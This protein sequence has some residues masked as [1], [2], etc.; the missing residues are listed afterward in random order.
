[1]NQR[2]LSF[3]VLIADLIWSLLAMSAAILLRYGTTGGSV[4]M[5]ATLSLVP[6]LSAT[7][8]IWGIL[9]L[10]VPLHGF[11]GGWRLSAVTSQLVLF[12]TC[13]LLVLLSGGYLSRSYVSRLV[14][15]QFGFLL[16]AGFILVRFV[17]YVLLRARSQNGLARRAVIV[18]RG[19][20][21]M[22]LAHKIE[23]HPE[24]LCRVIGF[25]AP[26]E[27]SLEGD[28]LPF[29]PQPST[30]TG[31]LGMANLLYE[32]R[33]DELIVILQEC[34]S[35]DLLNLIGVCRSRGIRISVVP[36]FYDLY[37]SRSELVD[38]D[39][40]PVLQF[41]KSGFSAAGL[42]WKRCFDIVL[43][44]LLSIPAIPLLLPIVLALR[45]G[46]GKAFRWEERCGLRAQTFHMLRL[47]ID[48]RPGNKSRVE[49]ILCELSLT[50]LPQLWNVL[51]GDMSIVGPR[52]EA[53]DRVHRYT[54]WQQQRLTV[55]PGIT[56][57][58]QVHGLREQHSSEEKTRFDLQYLVRP[59]FWAD[60]SLLLQT[61]WTLIT[62]TNSSVPIKRAEQPKARLSTFERTM[63]PEILENAHRP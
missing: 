29:F 3:G 63:Q 48:R 62:R 40:L 19:H 56:G 47:N 7:W 25:L 34:A 17:V 60:L 8:I 31:P 52:P 18:G 30:S 46:K 42:I 43:G 10:S 9:S 22:E 44:I 35:P 24:T 6:F 26:D 13:L 14:L 15:L 55:K 4:E 23:R 49:E 36:Q 33:I 21:A 58:A 11:H 28:E 54:E 5:A 2:Y 39:G 41:G 1:M 45:Y 37:L 27:R 38:L 57:L 59:S 61:L 32:K 16:L 20:L 51:K 50:E 53:P 12:V